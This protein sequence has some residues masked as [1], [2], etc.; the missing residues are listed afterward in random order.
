M[1]VRNR[2]RVAVAA[3]PFVMAGLVLGACGGS[4]AAGPSRS[5]VD[6]SSTAFVTRPPETT[7]TTIVGTFD[8]SIVAGEQEYTVQ[9]GDFP[10]RV[11]DLFGI[12]VEDIGAYNAWAGCTSLSC[13]QFPGIGTPIKIPPGATNVNAAPTVDTGVE[14]VT[15]GEVE[16]PTGDTIPA[17]GSNCEPGSYVVE[18]GDFEGRVATKF[19]VTVDALR[20]ANA[21]TPDYGVFYVGLPIVIP[22]KSDSDC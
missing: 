3:W 11:A 20:A 7:T 18:D 2:R 4:D 10:L 15:G 5:T 22:A 8:D 9:S 12:S 1:G 6:L 13:P 17:S 19:D 14:V 21:N 16:Q